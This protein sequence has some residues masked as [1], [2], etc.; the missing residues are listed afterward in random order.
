METANANRKE[1]KRRGHALYLIIIGILSVL[2]AVLAWQYWEQRNR[3]NEIIVIREQVETEK[4]QV[5]LDLMKLREEFSSLQ[6]TNGRMQK[7]L[8]EK[9]A[10]IDE[11]LEQAEKHKND[12]YIIS[13]L[14]RETE[15]LRTIM[16]HF[17][18]QIDSLNKLNDALVVEKEKVKTE[19]TE[20]KGKTQ[21]LT[22]EKEQLQNT[23]NLGQ[24]LKAGGIKAVCVRYR[25]GGKKEIETDKASRAEKIKVG[26]MLGE[27]RIAKSGNKDVYVRVITPDGK[28]MT[29]KM[30]EDHQFKFNGSKGYWAGKKTIDYRNEETQVFVFCPKTGNDFLPGKYII[31]VNAD[32]ATIGQTTL[33]LK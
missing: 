24:L 22:K 31:E 2:C 10:Q 3:A 33:T 7:E 18:H 20:E 32:E 21:T 12:A 9:K 11:L 26:F 23:V 30:D 16:K 27:N 15:T 19:L 29:E 4:N 25:S 1:E 6:T 5:Q 8:E 17:V 28:E 14:K 13:K